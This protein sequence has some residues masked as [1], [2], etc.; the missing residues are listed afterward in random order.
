[1]NPYE[2]L[3]L[4]KTANQEDIKR[5]YRKL[6]SQHHPDKG[7]NTARFQQIQSAYDVLSDPVKK[8]ELDNPS[9][10]MHFNFDQDAF[11]DIL[12]K[13]GFQH[14]FA[15]THPRKN[16]DIKTILHLNLEEILTDCTKTLNL[17]THNREKTIQITI[18]KGITNSTTIKYPNLG[19]TLFPNLPPGDLYITIGLIEHPKFKVQGLDLVTSLTIDCFQAILGCEQTIVGLDNRVFELKVPAGCQHGTKLKIS[20]QGLPGFQQDIKGNLLVQI[21]VSVPTKLSE[22]Q[23]NLLKDLIN[24]G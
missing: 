16:H 5:A 13:F 22:K 3:G 2:V 7:G 11:S 20:G 6:A 4:P 8:Q 19:E 14:P 12:S 1:M 15:R 17:Q 23:K 10:S 18:P 24:L 21:N 9:Q